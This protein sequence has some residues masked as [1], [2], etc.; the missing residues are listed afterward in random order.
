MAQEV[1]FGF[2]A[3]M[4]RWK[5]PSSATA[6]HCRRS[7]Q[8]PKKTEAGLIAAFDQARERIC[9][10]ADR[11]Y[12]RSPKGHVRHRT[13]R[14][15]YMIQDDVSVVALHN[16]LWI[17][18]HPTTRRR[19]RFFWHSPSAHLLRT[20]TTLMSRIKAPMSECPISDGPSASAQSDAMRTE[21]QNKWGRF[22]AEEVAALKDNQEL[23]SMLRKKYRLSQSEAEKIVEAFARGRQL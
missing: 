6:M 19:E 18:S 13:L 12:S 1:Q 10:V 17:Q 22:S 14:Q 9:T 15:R 3:M 16:A 5:Y 7:C 11:V 2:G 20:W 4:E 23:A 21:I 8:L